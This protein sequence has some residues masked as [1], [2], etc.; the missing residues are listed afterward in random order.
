MHTLSRLASIST[1]LLAAMLAM[2]QPAAA[3]H[4]DCGFLV[5]TRVVTIDGNHSSSAHTYTP[6]ASTD[7][8]TVTP[9]IFVQLSAQFRAETPKNVRVRVTLDGQPMGF[10]NFA[11][12]ATSAN[13]YDERAMTFVVMNSGSH[14]V[15][16]EFSS[17]D[18]TP[19]TV[20]N[21]LLR[22]SFNGPL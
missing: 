5:Q 9:C 3:E 4:I 10:P 8:E 1:I 20:R 14:T 6:L 22:V 12:A 2:A 11:N 21:G 18:G 15:G 7:I 13:S 17:A 19:V 16:V